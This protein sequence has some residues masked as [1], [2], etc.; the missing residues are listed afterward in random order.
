MRL[1]HGFSERF[2]WT[3][4]LLL[5]LFCLISCISIYNTQPQGTNYLG[6][7]IQ[8]YVI[9]SIAIAIIMYFDKEQIQKITWIFYGFFLFLLIGLLV[10][11]VSDFTPRINGAKSWYVI[12]MAGSVQPSEY[13]KVFYI[14]ALSIIIQKHHEKTVYQTI[15][16]DWILL[17]KLG[18]VAG[19]PIMLVIAQDFGTTLVLM[20]IL[21]GL[22]L[23]SGISWKIIIPLYGIAA[24]FGSLMLY[25]AV[26]G[27]EFL[28]KYF[29]IEAYKFARVTSW[30]NPEDAGDSGLQ[31]LKSMRAIG[32]GL[33]SGK[34]F[35]Q[36]EVYIPERHT[37]FIFTIIGEEYGFIGGSIVIVL[38]F[39]LI[40]HLVRTAFKT[41]DPYSTYISVGVISMITFHVFE[42]IG[43]TI[44]LLPITGI[45]LP[46]I[47]Y[48]GSSLMTNMMAMGLIFSIRYHHKSYM[49]SS[50]SFSF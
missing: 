20:A 37:D 2:D 9:A 8:W 5:I 39:I 23:V 6:S 28:E 48:G 50:N 24:A 35:G 16:T 15:K 45:P 32:S 43:M 10:L 47:S 34:G 30:L 25:L 18:L 44:Q 36:E 19:I 17:G 29:G 22:I 11:P 42:N 4:C 21:V 49:F 31:L 1:K 41:A 38:Y 7:Q 26:Y 46:F 14:L 33:V 12:P 27:R 13:M 3:L 40:S